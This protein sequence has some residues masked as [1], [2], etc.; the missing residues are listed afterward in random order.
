MTFLDAIASLEVGMSQ[1]NNLCQLDK[2][3]MKTWTGRKFGH[4]NRTKTWTNRKSYTCLKENL[5]T[6]KT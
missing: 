6:N 5:D 3:N 1:S 4:I 2:T